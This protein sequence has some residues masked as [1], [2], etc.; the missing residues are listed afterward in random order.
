MHIMDVMNF[1]ACSHPTPEVEPPAPKPLRLVV[2]VAPAVFEA[3]KNT[4][5][6]MSM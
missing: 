2:P 5:H 6:E 3:D 4:S 1:M